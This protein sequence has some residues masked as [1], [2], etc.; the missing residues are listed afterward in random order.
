MRTGPH[1][2]QPERNP[3]DG[4]EQEPEHEERAAELTGVDVQRRRALEGPERG[5]EGQVG[6]GVRQQRHAAD[7]ER[8]G[9]GT[10]ERTRRRRHRRAPA[11][12][13]G[14]DGFE[15]SAALPA[16]E[17]QST[18]EPNHEH[19]DRHPRRQTAEDVE[20]A[21]DAEHQQVHG[22][23]LHGNEGHAHPPEVA[24]VRRHVVDRG[25]RFDRRTR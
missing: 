15:L 22:D 8:D 18:A 25:G 11:V 13:L 7:Q 5:A 21:A 2:G 24:R 14:S 19:A 4:D 3:T 9:D 17:P 1:P 23:D 20:Q 12:G 6:G 10:D 16:R